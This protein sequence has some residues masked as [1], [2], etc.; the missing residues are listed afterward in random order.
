MCHYYH[1]KSLL[2]KLHR[3]V[4]LLKAYIPSRLPSG[5]AEFEA[6]SNDII[7]L[8]GAPKNDSIR[9]ALATMILH[10]DALDAYKSKH[11]FGLNVLKGMSN[12]VA[13]GVMHELKKKQEA[14]RAA[15]AAAI[16]VSNG[17]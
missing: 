2:V 9:F 7:D 17:S 3:A 16:V 5:M 4:R 1:M 14:D 6:W 12:Q 10:C 15:E 11:Y 13:S 8:Y